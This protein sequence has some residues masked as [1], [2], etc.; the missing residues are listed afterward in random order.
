MFGYVRPRTDKLTQEQLAEYKA[1]YC[2][3]CRALGKEYGFFARFLV[4]YDMTF[5]YLLR[6]AC[7]PACETK[8]CFCP[9]RLCG[10]KPC[11][12]DASGF[13]QVTAMTVILC[14]H[15]LED[16]IRD[17]GFFRRLLSRFLKLVYARAYRR[18][19]RNAPEFDALARRQM[20]RLRELEQDRSPSMDAAA[21]AF[22]ALIGGCA[23]ELPPERLRP[24]QTVLYQ[25]GRFVYLADALDD[26]AEDCRED[27]YNP[28]RLRFQPQD[29]R[30]C[31]QEL[32]YLAQLTDASVNLAGSALN[33]LELRCHEAILENIIYLGLPAVF[34]AVRQG[35]FRSKD[36]L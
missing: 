7:A 25:A 18:A 22:A 9:A 12:L 5:L 13:S 30:L 1:A 14:R 21:D 11:V 24:M 8:R 23:C 32:D 34:S 33:L 28:L 2:G 16:D 15:K 4:S 27:R 29:G 31:A 10:K 19:M 20:Q 35:S 17:S 3:L 26:L 36:K 6:S